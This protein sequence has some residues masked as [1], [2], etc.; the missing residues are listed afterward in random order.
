MATDLYSL[1]AGVLKVMTHNELSETPQQISGLIVPI[2][3]GL[4]KRHI[5][6]L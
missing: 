3:K 4:S 5:R 6:L 2:G 1:I